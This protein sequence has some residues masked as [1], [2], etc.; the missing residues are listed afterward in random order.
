MFHRH[1]VKSYLTIVKVTSKNFILHPKMYKTATKVISTP[2]KRDIVSTS[3]S[4]SDIQCTSSDSVKPKNETSIKGR[5]FDNKKKIKRKRKFSKTKPSNQKIRYVNKKGRKFIVSGTSNSESELEFI[6]RNSKIV[7]L[8]KVLKN[9]STNVKVP[10]VLKNKST[11]KK[12][13]CQST[14]LFES[15]QRIRD[16]KYN[17]HDNLLLSPSLISTK[18]N[19]L[20]S[21]HSIVNKENYEGINSSSNES[22]K[23]IKISSD[24]SSKEIDSSPVLKR[25]NEIK[26]YPPAKRTKWKRNLLKNTMYDEWP[27]DYKV[28]THYADLL[29]DKYVKDHADEF[30]E[31]YQA[32]VNRS[33]DNEK[34]DTDEKTSDS[35]SLEMLNRLDEHHLKLFKSRPLCRIRGTLNKETESVPKTVEEIIYV[36]D[37]NSISNKQKYEK[38]KWMVKKRDSF[39][40]KSSDSNNDLQEKS[41]NEFN[42]KENMKQSYKRSHRNDQND[43]CY[44]LPSTSSSLKKNPNIKITSSINLKSKK[45]KRGRDNNYYLWTEES[46]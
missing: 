3:C 43:E 44:F 15:P 8:P 5:T 40:Y 2:V 35:N 42:A 31:H 12:D 38:G 39:E 30:P 34:S 19:D 36:P 1:E 29:W 6:E 41:F 10:E 20:H 26:T 18:S 4:I 28:S 14:K 11:N 7:N 32:S 9:K 24:E 46:S 16:F 21:I 37:D 25:L 23:N 33:I 27:S 17:D 22:I 45:Y 13:Q